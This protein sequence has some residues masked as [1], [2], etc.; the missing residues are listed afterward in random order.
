MKKNKKT[1][2]LQF[3]DKSFSIKNLKNKQHLNL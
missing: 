1:N 2:Y 3:E